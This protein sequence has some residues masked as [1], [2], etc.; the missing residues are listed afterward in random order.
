MTNQSTK[1]DYSLQLWSRSQLRIKQQQSKF[2]IEITFHVLFHCCTGQ[3]TKETSSAIHHLIDTIVEQEHEIVSLCTPTKI[4][5]TS[6]GTMPRTPIKMVSVGTMP[7]TP[8][9][10]SMPTIPATIDLVSPSIETI[11]LCSPDTPTNTENSPSNS[12]PYMPPPPQ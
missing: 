11:D 3:T 5:M 12:T 2:K 8:T 9:M 7:K 1:D 4:I 6:T 10:K